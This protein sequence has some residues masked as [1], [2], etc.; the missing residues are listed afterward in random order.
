M[1]HIEQQFGGHL[2]FYEGGFVMPNSV[3]WL[4]RTAVNIT[5]ALVS[6]AEGGKNK[7]NLKEED[8]LLFAESSPSS[9][10]GSDDSSVEDESSDSSEL[11]SLESSP[12]IPKRSAAYPRF[13]CKRKGMRVSS[14][15]RS[16]LSSKLPGAI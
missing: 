14:S 11:S 13:V 6:I 9:P 5:D 4:D 1:M 8:E 2:G 15:L 16:V 7:A 10:N 12:M 3:T